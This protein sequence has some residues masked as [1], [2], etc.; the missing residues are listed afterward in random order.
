MMATMMGHEESAR[1]LLEAGADPNVRVSA[2]NTAIE[3]ARKYRQTHLY[4][5]LN[6]AEHLPR[7]QKFS[8]Y[9][10]SGAASD[11]LLP[12]GLFRLR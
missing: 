6:C 12:A 2:G 5:M 1:I 10:S 4:Q 8:N 3:F 11:S 9:C 7:G